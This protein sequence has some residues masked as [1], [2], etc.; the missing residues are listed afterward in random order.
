MASTPPD[1][2]TRLIE[3]E[4][5]ASSVDKET[6]DRKANELLNLL[7]ANVGKRKIH[8]RWTVNR[9]E[10]RFVTT[11]AATVNAILERIRELASRVR[12]SATYGP[13]E[14]I[15]PD[16]EPAFTVTNIHFTLEW[17]PPP[18]VSTCP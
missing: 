3:A 16:T 4:R 1:W 11:N 12:A 2:E 5:V 17:S 13:N 8:T 10:A 6:V 9:D 18:N 7:L 14:G 15:K